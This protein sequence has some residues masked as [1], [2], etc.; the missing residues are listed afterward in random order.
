M[1]YEAECDICRKKYHFSNKTPGDVVQ[2]HVCG[3][4]FEI[5][6]EGWMA[7]VAR[8][9]SN[10]D[11]GSILAVVFPAV[12]G[13]LF[14]LFFCY[15]GLEFYRAV[16]A[17]PNSNSNLA[18]NT[19]Q[20]N[21]M[22]PPMVQ[23]VPV[24][25]PGMNTV[26]QVPPTPFIVPGAQT[27]SHPQLAPYFQ[28]SKQLPTH[29]Q[30]IV[31]AHGTETAIIRGKGLSRIQRAFTINASMEGQPLSLTGTD[32]EIRTGL[33]GF[34]FD[35]LIV[36]EVPEGSLLTIPSY[37][38][39]L[40]A[41]SFGNLAP[42][43]FA[44]PNQTQTMRSAT[45]FVLLL[46]GSVVMTQDANPHSIFIKFKGS[47]ILVDP[48]D[49]FGR[50]VYVGTDD[51]VELNIKPRGEFKGVNLRAPIHLCEVPALLGDTYNVNFNQR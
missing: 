8:K 13:A 51:K 20:P 30:S 4:D 27:S 19:P 50:T 14:L 25:V 38:P 3:A 41:E 21:P 49:P 47:Q 16:S 1:S 43:K 48:R 45:H 33:R 12:G 46:P 28:R 11:S 9:E 35:E 22:I 24:N 15:C 29:I 44:P 32:E 6:T 2:C 34:R 37:T 18:M 40:N 39:E 17:K 7:T 23:S 42:V 5:P 10:E 36:A 26:N 31:S